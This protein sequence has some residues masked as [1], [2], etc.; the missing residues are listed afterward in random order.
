MSSILTV[1]VVLPASPTTLSTPLS[2]AVSFSPRALQLCIFILLLESLPD[3]QELLQARDFSPK[4]A[5][6]TRITSAG[7]KFK[8][9][10]NYSIPEPVFSV[11]N[12]WFRIVF[13]EMIRNISGGKAK[14]YQLSSSKG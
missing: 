12:V 5:R 13:P 7:T 1:P 6:A 4:A 14:M 8:K 11:Y 10:A 3:I 2:P 9:V